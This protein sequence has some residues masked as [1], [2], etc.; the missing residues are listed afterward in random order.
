MRPV[1]F[2]VPGAAR[3]LTGGYLYNQHIA[4][5]LRDLGW[6]VELL[7]L[8]ATFPHPTPEALRQAG[9]A[10]ARVPSGAILVIDSLALGAMPDLVAREARRQSIVGLMHLPLTAGLGL[11]PK[12]EALFEQG[13]RQALHAA[14]RVVVTGRAAIPMLARYELPEDRIAVVNPGVDPAPVARG[15]ADAEGTTGA[16]VQLLCVGTVNRAK[17][18]EVLMRALAAVPSR[19]W[20][21]TCVGNLNRDRASVARVRAVARELNLDV[22]VTFTGELAGQPLADAFDRADLFVTASLRETYGMAV[23]EALARGV[24]VVGTATGAMRDLVGTEAGVVVP[25]GDEWALADALEH[26]IANADLRAELADG[27]RAVRDRLP[28]WSAATEAFAVVLD[29]LPAPDDRPSHD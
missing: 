27:A 12:T 5:G 13:E 29:G 28:S 16:P 22:R 1:V 7:S 24:P 8:D 23:A 25:P 17:G 18:H 9:D 21:L 19:H 15:T 10:L 14:C 4:D 26:A 11:D 2:V 6:P 3:T 20:K